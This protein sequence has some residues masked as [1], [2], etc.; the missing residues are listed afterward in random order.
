MIYRAY[1]L[2]TSDFQRASKLAEALF[3][4]VLVVNDGS[5]RVAHGVGQAA[6]LQI[7]D[8]LPFIL[9]NFAG[10]AYNSNFRRH[11]VDHDGIGAYTCP[12]TDCY[13]SQHNRCRTDDH[14]VADG[15]VSLLFEQARAPKHH[16][17]IHEHIVSNLRC[18]ADDHTHAVVNE[19]AAPDFCSG[20]NFYACKEPAAM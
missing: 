12:V 6:M 19:N 14:T 5:Q 11:R 13:R 10:D 8:G 15:G 4:L 3:Q 16:T 1:S 20:V 18:F 17:L 2:F 7:E 9:N